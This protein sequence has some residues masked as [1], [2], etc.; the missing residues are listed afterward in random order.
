MLLLGSNHR[1]CGV[2]GTWGRHTRRLRNGCPG[3]IS[4]VAQ[5]HGQLPVS[6]APAYGVHAL[7]VPSSIPCPVQQDHRHD[8]LCRSVLARMLDALRRQLLRP[9]TGTA[10]PW[11][12]RSDTFTGCVSLA[13]WEISVHGIASAGWACAQPLSSHI[14][15]SSAARISGQRMG[16][17][18][19]M[20]S[21]LS[22]AGASGGWADH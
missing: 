17:S 7:Y 11:A 19:C 20:F 22:A 13:C 2:Q 9:G 12:K 15:R 10:E 4:H 3:S 8:T 16:T 1:R 5:D 18:A 6:I 21:L 14:S